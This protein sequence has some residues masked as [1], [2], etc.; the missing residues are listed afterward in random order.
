MTG[1]HMWHRRL[2]K[3]SHRSHML[4]LHTRYHRLRTLLHHMS[5]R[6]PS[7]PLSSRRR[8]SL[9][10]WWVSHMTRQRALPQSHTVGPC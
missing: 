8:P 7:L 5:S 4:G 1:L 9:S 6:L 2:H 3:R 10:P